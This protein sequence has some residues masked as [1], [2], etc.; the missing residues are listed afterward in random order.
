[1]IRID[2]SESLIVPFTTSLLRVKIHFHDTR[3]YRGYLHCSG[4]ECLA[5]RIGRKPEVRDL[6]P[7]YDAVARA[8]G[9]LAVSESLRPQALRPQLTP[10]LRQ[11]RQGGRLILSIR[12]SDNVH[13]EVGTLDLP[14]DA[15]DGADKI[16]AF[17]RQ[18]E[19]G[20]IDLAAVYPHIDN[21]ELAQIPEIA[22]AM[23]LKGISLS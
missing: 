18:L 16:L 13:F 1:L 5:C 6:L 20:S 11:L 9:V 15:D 23:H 8:V 22:Q 19:A 3:A 4:A 7:V 17:S 21:E 12:K 14:E 10:I 2:A